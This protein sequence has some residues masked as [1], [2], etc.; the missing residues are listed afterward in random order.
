MFSLFGSCSSYSLALS[1]SILANVLAGFDAWLLLEVELLLELTL[2]LVVADT[3]CSVITRLVSFLGVAGG[4][5][6][7]AVGVAFGGG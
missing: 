2:W 5:A 6:L 7:L 3:D 4:G 1:S